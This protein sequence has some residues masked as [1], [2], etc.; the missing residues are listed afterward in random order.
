MYDL[1][2]NQLATLRVREVFFY[3][4]P[5]FFFDRSEPFPATEIWPVSFTIGDTEIVTV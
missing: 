2:L 4:K 3:W 1:V 5:R